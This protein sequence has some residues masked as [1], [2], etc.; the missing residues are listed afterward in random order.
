MSQ[1]WVGLFA[2]Q[3]QCGSSVAVSGRDFVLSL[4][5]LLCRVGFLGISVSHGAVT[6][7]NWTVLFC[8]LASSEILVFD[9]NVVPQC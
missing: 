9:G 6:S 4:M 2:S 7:Q 1:N 5:G 8:D 3:H